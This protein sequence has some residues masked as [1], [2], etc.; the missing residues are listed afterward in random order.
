L[1]GAELRRKRR[2]GAPGHDALMVGPDV[3][4]ADVVAHDHDDVRLLLR[5]SGGDEPHQC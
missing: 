2:A 4:P 5:C 3:E 1:H